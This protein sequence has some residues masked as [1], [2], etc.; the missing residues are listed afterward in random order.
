MEDYNSLNDFCED[1]FQAM[2]NLDDYARN[3]VSAISFDNL[4]LDYS[5]YIKYCIDVCNFA[6][7]EDGIFNTDV[8]IESIIMACPPKYVD[9][10][11][12]EKTKNIVLLLLDNKDIKEVDNINICA[13]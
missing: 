11:L 6:S 2:V 3:A 7:T 1:G 13:L 8:I 9:E 5:P 12:K 10:R 4:K